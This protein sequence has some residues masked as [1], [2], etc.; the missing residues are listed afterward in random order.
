MSDARSRKGRARR[1]AIATSLVLLAVSAAVASDAS[2]FGAALRI[3]FVVGVV[4]WLF[5]LRERFDARWVFV[6][7]LLIR[8]PFCMAPYHSNDVYRYVFEGRLV[9]HGLSPYAISPDDARGAHLHDETHG[10][11]NHPDFATIYPPLAQAFFATCVAAGA[12]AT[13]MRNAVLVLDLLVVVLLLAWLRRTGRPPRY[14]IVYAWS[15]LAVAGAAVGHYDPLMLLFLVGVGVASAAKRTN[16]AGALLGL[17]ILA[18][19]MAVLL[20]PWLALRHRRAFALALLVVAVG[21]APFWGDDVFSSLLSFGADFAFNGSIYRGLAWLSSAHATLLAGVLLVAWTALVALTQPR[22]SVACA[23]TMAGLLAL[24]PTVHFW[25]LTWFLAVLGAVGAQRWTW[26]LLLWSC[27]ALFSSE[28]Y[29]A[30]Y[31]GE[32]FLERFA[33]TWLEYL[34]PLA[35]ALWLWWRRSP[36]RV[37]PRPAQH[38]A[39]LAG[40][41]G[42]VIP[43][44]GEF[45]NLESLV[46]AW[47]AAGASRIVLADTP[48]DD[49]TPTLADGDVVRYAAVSQ[50]GYGVAVQLGMNVC[51]DL[52]FVVV[53]DADHGRGPSQVRALLAPFGDASIGLACGARTNTNTLTAPQRWGNALSCWL[54]G[55]G[56]GQRFV[57]LGPF[58]ALRNSAWPHGALRDPGFG[59]NVEMNVRALEHGIGVVEVELPG[60]EREFGEN[61]IS[62]TVRGVVRTGYGML[63]R[64]F[65]LREE[66]CR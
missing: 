55:W 3:Y 40:A 31:A 19:T 37:A 52:P 46:P 6:V 61:Q 39:A 33:L 10:K 49:G 17:A 26:P 2:S 35:L 54:I 13:A 16:T 29:R 45:Q 1:W 51:A 7:A 43:C 28:T 24:S 56:W 53:C 20:L 44:R 63:H 48:T 50:R 66:T 47:R 34:P 4:A 64:I 9:T 14:A 21:Y 65:H 12:H 58:R 32:P 36:R 23:L 25:Y 27:T 41:Y 30:H 42:V 8:A 5:A 59:W 18:K 11:I 15:P 38:D 57:D 62:A 22:W 60:S